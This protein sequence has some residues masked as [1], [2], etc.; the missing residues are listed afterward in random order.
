MRRVRIDAQLLKPCMIPAPL[1][2]ARRNGASWSRPFNRLPD[3]T[4]VPLESLDI[5]LT[6]EKLLHILPALLRIQIPA[7]FRRLQYGIEG[8]TTQGLLRVLLRLLEH[9]AHLGPR[10][11]IDDRSPPRVLRVRT[12]LGSPLPDLFDAL[13]QSIVTPP[14]SPISPNKFGPMSDQ[15]VLYLL[16]VES[17]FIREIR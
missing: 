1:R 12:P 11:L 10:I 8:S 17:D 7:Q 3:L 4:R 16:Q 5:G 13:L 14:A 9:P 6:G 2:D 15:D